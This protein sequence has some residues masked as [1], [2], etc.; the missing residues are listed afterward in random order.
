MINN[1]STFSIFKIGPKIAELISLLDKE[2]YYFKIANYHA[3]LWDWDGKH[4]SY[5]G[6]IDE[7]C[8]ILTTSKEKHPTYSDNICLSYKFNNPRDDN[9]ICLGLNNYNHNDYQNIIDGKITFYDYEND[10]ERL[11]NIP[12]I[13][14]IYS[15]IDYLI[16]FKINNNM[17]DLS[18]ETIGIL[19]N[20]FI[21]ENHLIKEDK[22]ILR[23]QV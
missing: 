22:R 20:D 4:P 3:V 23:K 19:L 11:I 13:D 17:D 5:V 21:K 1:D 7:S 16:S 14:T 18:S 10:Q 2:T 12:Y 9:D 6:S 8:F 15:F